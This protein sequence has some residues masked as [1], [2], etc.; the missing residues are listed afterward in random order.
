MLG[1][2]SLKYYRHLKRKISLDTVLPDM[3]QHLPFFSSRLFFILHRVAFRNSF[4]KWEEKKPFPTF[5][6]T[7]DPSFSLLPFFHR[8]IFAGNFLETGGEKIIPPC[9][10]STL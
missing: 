7:S 6:S 8:V 4:T 10:S 2:K 3:L 1:W 5:F 9:P